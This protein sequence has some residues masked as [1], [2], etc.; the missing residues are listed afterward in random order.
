M[1]WVL[2]LRLPTVEKVLHSYYT[3]LSHRST[4]SVSL[5]YV[6]TS[7]DELAMHVTLSRIKQEVPKRSLSV[8]WY[9]LSYWLDNQTALMLWFEPITA[10][11]DCLYF[12]RWT[13]IHNECYTTCW[14]IFKG[15]VMWTGSG[16]VKKDEC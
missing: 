6:R 1:W 15:A 2:P 5:T 12:C 16:D 11:G 14:A 3:I 9:G 8:E 4:H 13:L 7:T 10:T